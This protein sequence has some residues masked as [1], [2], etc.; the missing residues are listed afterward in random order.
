MEKL[1]KNLL[2]VMRNG[3]TPDIICLDYV[4]GENKRFMRVGKENS[5]S[6]KLFS[7][8]APIKNLQNSTV[9]LS[10]ADSSVVIKNN[11]ISVNFEP[12]KRIA[13][14][15]PF[16][17]YCNKK[18]PE[19][20]APSWLKF[21]VK[22]TFESYEFEDELIVPV[23]FNVPSFSGLSIDDGCKIQGSVFGSGNGDGIAEPGENIMIYVEG[24]RTRLYC[25]DPFVEIDQEKLVDEVLPARW[26][27]GFTLSSVIKI[28]KTCPKGHKI[29]FLANYETKS[30]MPINR[31][32][33]WGK[34]VLKIE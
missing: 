21:K 19:D 15:S 6:L 30:F 25:D 2:K 14:S 5:M 23:F 27:D 18:P 26:P 28:S 10:C 12:D 13:S 9:L 29:E 22:I 34:I 8:G 1:N 32:L 4:L 7:R 3:D 20:G 16:M 24:H 31:K 33:I 11:D 17:V